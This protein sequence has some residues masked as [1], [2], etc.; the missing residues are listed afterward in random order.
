MPGVPARHRSLHA[1]DH[2]LGE[3]YADKENSGREDEGTV[4]LINSRPHVIATC[5]HLYYQTWDLLLNEL[6][7]RFQVNCSLAPVLALKSRLIKAANGEDYNTQMQLLQNSCFSGYLDFP[8]LQRHLS[9][10]VDVV[11]QS[12]P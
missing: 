8:A 2:P 12:Y 1:T 7:D 4:I 3:S 6:Q 9:V 10:L 5:R 11:K